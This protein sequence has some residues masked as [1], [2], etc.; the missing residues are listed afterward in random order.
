MFCFSPQGTQLKYY[1]YVSAN[2]A[3]WR[4][5]NFYITFLATDLLSSSQEPKAYQAKVCKFREEISVTM[6]RVKPTELSS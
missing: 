4:G 1:K 3:P 6:V 2:V 5:H